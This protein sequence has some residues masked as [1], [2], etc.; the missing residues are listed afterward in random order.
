MTA[1]LALVFALSSLWAAAADA[2]VLKIADVSASSSYPEEDGVN[3]DVKN[4]KDRKQ[5]T[6][7]VEGE[8]GSG[9]GSWVEVNLGETKTVTGFRIWNGNWYSADFWGRHNRV[10]EVEVTLSDDSKHTFTLKDEMTPE[11][12]RFPKAVQTSSIKIKV[13]SVYNGSTF[14]DTCIS[15]VQVVDDTP[16]AF[17]PVA[18]YNASSIYPADA[19][20]SY[21]PVNM[22]DGL[23]DSMWCEGSKDGDGTGEWVEFNFGSARKVARLELVNGNAYDFKYNLKANRATAAKLEFDNGSTEITIKPSMSPQTI[24]FP[25]QTTSKV[26]VTFTGVAKG[27]E[28]ND[29]CISEARFGE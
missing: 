27:T 9:L 6:V 22:A 4:V 7:W 14:N 28:F 19:D 21:D 25:A 26:K 12:I 20:G 13:K 29:L 18:N 10:K 24:T 5:S 17:V 8:S 2:S 23:L 11:L 3:Y 16:E 1:R 15:E